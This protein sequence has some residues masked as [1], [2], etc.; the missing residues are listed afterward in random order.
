MRVT[1]D[2]EVQE[3]GE[4][5]GMSMLCVDSVCALV[6]GGIRISF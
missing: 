6:C 4:E 3:G 5:N 2:L 1:P